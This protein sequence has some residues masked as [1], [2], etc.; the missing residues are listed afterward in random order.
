MVL[1]GY[2]KPFFNIAL[3]IKVYL[4]YIY[5]L[6]VMVKTPLGWGKGF[7][8]LSQSGISTFSSEATVMDAEWRTIVRGPS[9]WD[10]HIALFDRTTG[11]RPRRVTFTL[12][13]RDEFWLE[14]LITGVE[15]IGSYGEDWRIKGICYYPESSVSHEFLAE[16]CTKDRTGKACYSVNE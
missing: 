5:F 12:L 13:K 16:Y 10:I 7:W 15:V 1:Y 9:L 6:I 14:V 4:M 11:S 2:N 8:F 3:D